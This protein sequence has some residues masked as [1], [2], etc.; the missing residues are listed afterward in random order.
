MVS[1][2]E[3][4]KNISYICS[5]FGMSRMLKHKIEIEV[6]L[7]ILKKE[8]S[9]EIHMQKCIQKYQKQLNNLNSQMSAV[10]LACT[11]ETKKSTSYH[12]NYNRFTHTYCNK[13]ACSCIEKKI[14]NA[15]CGMLN[16]YY[17]HWNSDHQ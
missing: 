14:T 10:F 5:K 13:T 8:N 9:D 6:F 4:R 17:H 1:E 12:T 2:H 16:I 7:D 11:K 3:K 15:K